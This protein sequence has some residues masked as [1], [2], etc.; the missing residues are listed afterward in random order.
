ML[1]NL[2]FCLLAFMVDDGDVWCQVDIY[3]RMIAYLFFLEASRTVLSFLIFQ[4]SII[5]YREFW[6]FILLFIHS[7]YYSMNHMSLKAD[8]FLQL[9]NPHLRSHYFFEYFYT[10][11]LC[12]LLLE[13]L[14]YKNWD[15]WVYPPHL[16]TSNSHFL[17]LFYFTL[18]FRRIPWFHLSCH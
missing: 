10:P 3:S 14:L 6:N 16:M 15:C 11:I 2:L 5:I 13:L 7:A 18:S 8:V 17:F 9:W 4:T 12:F 1:K